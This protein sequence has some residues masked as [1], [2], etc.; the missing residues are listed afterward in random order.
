MSKVLSGI[1]LLGIVLSLFLVVLIF[2]SKSF[3]SDVH[4]YFAAT[5]ISLNALLPIPASKLM[6]LPMGQW[7]L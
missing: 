2:S 6:S 7:R 5:I 4:K 3:R 1:V